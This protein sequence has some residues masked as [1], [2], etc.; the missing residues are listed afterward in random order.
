MPEF[1]L[2]YGSPEGAR[3]FRKLD[4]FTQGYVEAMFFTECHSDNPELENATVSDLSDD[5]WKTIQE[6]CT[7]FQAL[8]QRS[9]DLA[10]DYATIT[11]DAERAGR[12]FWYTR[13]R[14]G[15]GYWDRGLGAVGDQLTKDAKS[16][17]ECYLYMGDDEKLYLD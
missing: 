6:D 12:D 1:V 17:S 2:D 9:L 16:F 15:V 14:H 11:Y 4:S 13:N 7:A 8:T 3:N 5:A 10:Y